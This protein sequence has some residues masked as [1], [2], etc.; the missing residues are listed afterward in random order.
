MEQR[1]QAGSEQAMAIDWEE[2]TEEG[3]AGLPETSRNPQDL[4][5]RQIL[6]RLE[7]GGLVRIPLRGSQ[8]AARLDDPGA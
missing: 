6:A 8:G 1:E 5:W 7:A 2:A 4:V 3:F